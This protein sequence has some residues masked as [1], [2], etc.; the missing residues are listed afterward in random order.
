MLLGD[1]DP[2]QKGR[3]LVRESEGPGDGRGGILGG[4]V[5]GWSG[6]SGKA[7]RKKEDLT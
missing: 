6:V 1:S 3:V 4:G 5:W 7:L 2:Q